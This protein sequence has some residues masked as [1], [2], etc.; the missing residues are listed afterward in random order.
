MP[1]AGTKSKSALHH[2]H[3]SVI[4]ALKCRGNQDTVAENFCGASGL[5]WPE[6]P[7]PCGCGCSCPPRQLAEVPTFRGAV[8][9][10]AMGLFSTGIILLAI[11]KW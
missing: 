9:S 11:E 1:G 4:V 7:L 8:A 10:G 2:N 5:A 3:F 6:T